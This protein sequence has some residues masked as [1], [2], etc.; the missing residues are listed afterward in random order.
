MQ[1]S[2]NLITPPQQALPITFSTPSGLRFALLCTL[3]LMA[4]L[5]LEPNL[6]PLCLTTATQVA[7]LL[8]LA[9]L[10]PELNGDLITLSGFT[11]RV[12]PEC[13]PLYACLLYGAF[14]LAQPASWGR[15]LMGLITG[16]MVIASV[17]LIRIAVITAV[18]PHVSH[19]Q[20]DIL[21]VY[22]G[23]VVMLMLVVGSALVWSRW[24]SGS[25]SPF[26]FLLLAGFNATLLFLPWVSVNRLYVA[27]LD[28]CV[29]GIFSLVMPGH[30]LLTSRPFPLY[31]HT[32]A[33]PLFLA[34]VIAGDGQWTG[35]RFWSTA[36]GVC[37]LAGWHALFRIT[38]VVWTALDV[39]EIEPLHQGVYLLGQ[40]LLPFLLWLLL[41][42]FNSPAANNL[43]PCDAG[44]KLTDNSDIF[45]Q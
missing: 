38:H 35:R 22:L 3:F 33:V 19:L 41:E 44:K 1:S 29:A 2:K 30:Q 17:N 18:G 9:G 39:P 27:F 8:N 13:T 43:S 34:L 23:Q 12:V 15:T 37:T 28:W 25:T 5:W 6:A 21:H 14:V 20:F 40:F 10:A 24:I 7:T 26:P 36:A 42:R 31:N 45:S 32:F 4:A 11:V 16:M